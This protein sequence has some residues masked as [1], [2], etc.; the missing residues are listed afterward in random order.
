MITTDRA[1]YVI[2]AP[3]P[4]AVYSFLHNDGYVYFIS[5]SESVNMLECVSISG[6]FEHPIELTSFST[7]CDCN[8]STN[9]CY[10]ILTTDYPLQPHYID[11]IKSE[12]VREL[13]NLN[14]L[15]E[16]NLNDS[17]DN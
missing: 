11:I 8:D 1:P 14:Q 13:A 6:I 12:I 7:C 5:K 10:D 9:S 17:N 16:D 3:F 4:N 2:D 15:P